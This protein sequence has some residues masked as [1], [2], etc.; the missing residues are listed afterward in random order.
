MCEMLNIKT[1][2]C[3]RQRC[4][5]YLLNDGRSLNETVQINGCYT[6]QLKSKHPFIFVPEV[7]ENENVFSLCRTVNRSIHLN[8][9]ECCFYLLTGGQSE[10][11]VCWREPYVDLEFDKTHVQ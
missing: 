3:S 11:T 9:R 8:L 5:I 4:P 7:R 10:R 2:Q 1:A 6:S